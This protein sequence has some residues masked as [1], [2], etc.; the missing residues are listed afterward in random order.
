MN[1]LYEEFLGYQKR[2]AAFN[3]AFTLLG[4]DEETL[5]PKGANEFSA[6][7]MGILSGEYY[8]L[9]TDPHYMEIVD[10]LSKD[11]TLSP[12]EKELI[13]RE[14]KGIEQMAVIPKD[15][16]AAYSE[17]LSRST[18][19]WQK[20]KR[21]NDFASFAPT[22]KEVFDTVKKL[23]VYQ[24]KNNWPLYDVV[25]D[26]YEEGFLMK[27]LD[28]FFGMLRTEIVPLLKEA[29]KK[30]DQIRTDFLRR[31][32]DV[33][34]QREFNRFLA[35]YVGFDLNRGVISVSEHPF[36]TE[37]HKNDVRITTAYFENMPES[38]IF[39]TIH[40][41]GHAM[42]EQD[43]PDELAFVPV[44]GYS[45]GIHESQS[46]LNEN[47]IG[48]SL[49]FWKPIY[50]KL[51]ETFPEQL[52]DV[53]LNEWVKAINKPQASLIRTESD[54]LTYCLHIM[55][56]Y[57][58]EKKVFMEDYP[59]DKLPELWNQMYKEYLG[60]DV[61]TDTEGLLQDI[62]WSQG[63]IGYFPTYALGNAIAAQI[64]RVMDKE[65]GVDACLLA[66]QPEKIHEWLKDNV[67]VYAGTMKVQDLLLKVTGE[68]FNPKYYVDYLK[69][70][71]TKLYE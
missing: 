65:I 64:Y 59:I 16:Y 56:R 12:E 43:R 9:T 60:V 58:I 39:S 20:A 51:Q 29:E 11:E 62:H 24:N 8:T 18:S 21:T 6:E 41:S 52:S 30:N 55:I 70:K 38:A 40:E 50:G 19:I 28:E 15:E 32:Y 5:Q 57:E 31:S 53:T 27:E 46:R 13:R 26:Q 22:L 14:K 4:W 23:T 37:L 25:L 69:D 42:F 7:I 36:T 61:P 63:S 45:M 67:H 17:L 34:K 48:R 3:A 2:Q 71:F 1:A 47:M 68:T 66:G 49:S 35:E 33:E 54:E 44:S 10:T